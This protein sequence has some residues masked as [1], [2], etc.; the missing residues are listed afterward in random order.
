MDNPFTKTYW[1]YPTW[2]SWKCNSFPS[3]CLSLPPFSA[4]KTFSTPPSCLGNFSPKSMHRSRYWWTWILEIVFFYLPRSNQVSHYHNFNRIASFTFRLLFTGHTFGDGPT[5]NS[6]S[7]Q[8]LRL[9]RK[10][11]I[12][13]IRENKQ[14][15]KYSCPL[16]F[17]FCL[18]IDHQSHSLWIN[19]RYWEEAWWFQ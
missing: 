15:D 17:C 14:H 1:N 3:P 5:D 19:L 10:L 8:V 18:P 12:T 6:F 2:E 11:H 13:W 16:L 7:F 9:Q 4:F